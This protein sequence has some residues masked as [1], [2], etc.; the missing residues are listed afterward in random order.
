MHMIF[1][2]LAFMLRV[3]CSALLMLHTDIQLNTVHAS[4]K[5]QLDV[6]YTLGRQLTDHD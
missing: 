6:C 2:Q 4:Q 1:L 3:I 5:R